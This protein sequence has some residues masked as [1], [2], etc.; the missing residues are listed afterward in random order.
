MKLY[1]TSYVVGLFAYL[2]QAA[3]SLD[4]A[5]SA[6]F[7]EELRYYY[8]SKSLPCPGD[9]AGSV[10]LQGQSVLSSVLRLSVANRILLSETFA[11]R[12]RAALNLL[13]VLLD[14][15][16]AF[17]ENERISLRMELSALE[18]RLARKLP[19]T[20]RARGANIEHYNQNEIL[21]LRPLEEIAGSEWPV[22]DRK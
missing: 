1:S 10:A 14:G 3:L 19:A 18:G 16:S 13:R 4:R 20:E 9:V 2:R 12:I 7:S 11:G 22:K 15:Q 5:A 21:D 6:S 8:R 17:T